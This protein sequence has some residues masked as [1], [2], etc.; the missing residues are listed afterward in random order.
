M[1]ASTVWSL[2][3]G[4]LVVAVVFMLVRPGAPAASAVTGVTDA[5][6]NMITTSVHGLPGAQ[7]TPKAT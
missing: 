3:T 2:L 5:L 6:A 1:S 7:S 4:I